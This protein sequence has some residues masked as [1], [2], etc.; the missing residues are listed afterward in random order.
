MRPTIIFLNVIIITYF[1]AYVC[2]SGMN[3]KVR[4]H[5]QAN[6]N[7]AGWGK[8]Y[9]NICLDCNTRQNAVICQASEWFYLKYRIQADSV[10]SASDRTETVFF[11]SVTHLHCY[12]CLASACLAHVFV[13]MRMRLYASSTSHK[14]NTVFLC[15]PWCEHDIHT[16][17][18]SN[19]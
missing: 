17:C 11:S 15:L 2:G 4:P 10:R 16:S 1:V 19:N 3:L 18:S 9:T 5:L 6:T 8:A 13:L 12:A 7:E 14:C